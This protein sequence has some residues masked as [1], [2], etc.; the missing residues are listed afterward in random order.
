MFVALGTRL[1]VGI[2]RLKQL[3]EALL[4]QHPT[5]LQSPN[6]HIEKPTARLYIS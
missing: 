4:V 5:L 2:Q 1:S 6:R 3:L